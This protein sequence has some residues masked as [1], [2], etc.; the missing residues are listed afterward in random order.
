MARLIDLI[1]PI[2]V[3]PSR[4]T[5]RRYSQQEAI[6]RALEAHGIIPS[7]PDLL[8]K[9]RETRSLRGLSP[10]ERQVELAGS[11]A[12]SARWSHLVQGLTILLVDDVVTYGAHFREAKKTLAEGDPGAILGC[13]VAT[14]TTNFRLINSSGRENT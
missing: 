12:L 5:V 2:P 13:A 3:D 4:F 10:A 6:A 14:G 7:I 1:A 8:E 9:T 11:M